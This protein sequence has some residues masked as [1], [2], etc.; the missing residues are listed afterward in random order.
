MLLKLFKQKFKYFKVMNKNFGNFEL[1]DIAAN[2]SDESFQGIYHGKK[3]H[4]DDTDEVIQRAV[5]HNV[6]RMLF[7]AGSLEDAY[8]SYKLAQKSDNFYITVGIHPCRALVSWN[9]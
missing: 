7:A 5:D 1:F 8:Q 3:Y 6:T 4:E 2:L 9:I